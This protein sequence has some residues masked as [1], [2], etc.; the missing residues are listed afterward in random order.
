MKTEQENLFTLIELLIV[1]S[2]IAI[3][4]AIIMPALTSA[5]NRA[6]EAE[7]ANNL[8]LISL[9]M[10][11]YSNDNIEKIPPHDIGARYQRASSNLVKDATNKRLGLSVFITSDYNIRYRMF[12]CLLHHPRLPK[13]V[14]ADWEAGGETKSAYLYRETDN[15]FN[16]ILS[17]PS[18]GGKAVVMDFSLIK[19]DGTT[20]EIA[21]SFIKTNIL[22]SDGHVDNEYNDSSGGKRFTAAG[23]GLFISDET[24]ESIDKV[25]DNADR[26]RQK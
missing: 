25:W 3:L 1:I 16:E 13:Q 12:G 4:A 17:H 11:L 23:D 10:A 24:A 7:C 22:F 20:E 14:I 15:D 8:K 21:H 6:K 2:I 9:A 18:N 26:N 5:R 19:T